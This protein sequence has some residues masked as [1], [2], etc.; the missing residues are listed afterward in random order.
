LEGVTERGNQ[1]QR[2]LFSKE[3]RVR[4]ETKDEVSLLPKDIYEDMLYVVGVHEKKMFARL[5]DEKENPI[6]KGEDYPFVI[7]PHIDNTE[8]T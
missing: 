3:K 5:Y 4:E 6:P 2:A 1:F 8:F 7:K